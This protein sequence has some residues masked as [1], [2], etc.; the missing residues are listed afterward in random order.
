[1]HKLLQ[2]S[3]AAALVFSM[4]LGHAAEG[5]APTKQQTRMGT[6]SADFKT[7]GK[8]GAERKAFMKEC[9]SNARQAKD[10]GK[11][12]RQARMGT[13][14][15]DFKATGKPGAERKAF[16]KECL[17]NKPATASAAAEPAHEAVKK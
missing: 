15:A 10:E 17:S 1:M 2:L 16:M 6:C 13:C 12:K 3:A 5:D 14:S 7:S 4:G 9:L 8:P 11:E